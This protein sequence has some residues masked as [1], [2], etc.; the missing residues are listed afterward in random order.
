MEDSLWNPS[1]GKGDSDVK[2]EGFDCEATEE[3][4]TLEIRMEKW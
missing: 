3:S 4:E 2:G 1:T